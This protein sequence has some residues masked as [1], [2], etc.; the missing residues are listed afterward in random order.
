MSGAKMNHKTQSV[1]LVILFLVCSILISCT[2]GIAPESLLKGPKGDGEAITGVLVCSRLDKEETNDSKMAP[3]GC[4]FTDKAGQKKEGDFKDWTVVIIDNEYKP[5]I[6]T[7]VKVAELDSPW[8]IL[9]E[10]HEETAQKAT[11]IIVTANWN[12][13]EISDS[14]DGRIL[15]LCLEAQC[16]QIRDQNFTVTKGFNNFLFYLQGNRLEV[17]LPEASSVW[18]GFSVKFRSIAAGTKMIRVAEGKAIYLWNAGDITNLISN[19][20]NWLVLEGAMIQDEIPDHNKICPDNYVFIPPNQALGVQSFC[21]GK[22]EASKG[23]GPE[24]KAE[25]LPNT[26]PWHSITQGEAQAA[27][28]RLGPGF[29]LLT[30]KEWQVIAR[31]IEKV[32]ENWSSGVVGAGLLNTGHSDNVPEAGLQASIDDNESC[33]QTGETCNLSEWNVQRRTFRLSTGEILWDMSGGVAEWISGVSTKDYSGMGPTVSSGSIALSHSTSDLKTDFGPE[34][35][36]YDKPIGLGIGAIQSYTYLNYPMKR[37]GSYATHQGTGGVFHIRFSVYLSLS[38]TG[39]RCK[40]R[41]P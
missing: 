19:G 34:G 41:L 21:V 37:G 22:Y 1:L 4:S 23:A 13:E 18:N 6:I 30:N 10:V 2:S 25:T 16:E 9:F 15:R 35:N 24:Y 5:H 7:T 11:E 40:Y 26:L 17:T 3:V 29:A 31:D 27:C 39:F 32:P 28:G 8:H 36:Y 33:H 14:V 12:G 38:N 20:H